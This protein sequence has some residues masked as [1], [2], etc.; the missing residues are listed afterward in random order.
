MDPAWYVHSTLLRLVVTRRMSTDEA[1]GNLA[2]RMGNLEE[3]MTCY[4]RALTANPNSIN[5]LN[6]LS[7][8]LRT[9]ENF[10][11]AA[12]YLHAIIKLDGNNGE[13]WGS[14][15]TPTHTVNFGATKT[16]NYLYR[17]LLPHDGRPSTGIPGLPK[18]PAEIAQS[19]RTTP[20]VRHRYSL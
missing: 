8:V 18:C 9:Q 20:V 6:A 4:E 15:G 1:A 7:V 17:S 14:L 5:A 3:A 19:Q 2:E 16:D 11:K 13:A 10:P 12:E